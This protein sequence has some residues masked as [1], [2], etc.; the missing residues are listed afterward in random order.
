M[1][2]ETYKENVPVIDIDFLTSKIVWITISEVAKFIVKH[3]K[4]V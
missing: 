4:K 3:Q 2:Q 1:K